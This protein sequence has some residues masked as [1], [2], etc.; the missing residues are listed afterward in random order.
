MKRSVSI[1][2]C[3]RSGKT[4]DGKRLVSRKADSRAACGHKK[5]LSREEGEMPAFTQELSFSLQHKQSV[6]LRRSGKI[7][8]GHRV[9]P[10]HLKIRTGCVIYQTDDLPVGSL[11][12]GNRLH[13]VFLQQLFAAQMIASD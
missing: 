4:D 6:K 8:T 5:L 9:H 1:T 10:I 12:E 3:L 2:R 11:A 7:Q 13:H